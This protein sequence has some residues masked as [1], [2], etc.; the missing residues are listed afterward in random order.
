[1]KAPVTKAAAKALALALAAS[2]IAPTAMAQNSD[3]TQFG[4]GGLPAGYTAWN[5]GLM[6]S[7]MQ[8]IVNNTTNIANNATNIANN[9]QNSAN[10][11]QNTANYGVALAGNA[12][13]TAN[14]ALGTANANAGAGVVSAAYSYTDG[15][16]SGYTGNVYGICTGQNLSQS[17]SYK[18]YNPHNA[19]PGNMPWFYAVYTETTY[20]DH[21]GP[22]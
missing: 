11:A 19:C 22:N 17:T 2:A 9:A 8:T 4:T 10:N 13:N 3:S 1:M 12:Q 14:Q 20:R 16:P 5:P 15:L 21:D 6:A 7:Q 18:Q